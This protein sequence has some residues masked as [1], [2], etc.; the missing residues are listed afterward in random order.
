MIQDLT[1]GGPT[2]DQSVAAAA[3]SNYTNARQ[4]SQFRWILPI[5]ANHMGPQGDGYSAQTPLKMLVLITDGVEGDRGYSMPNAPIDKPLDWNWKPQISPQTCAAIKDSG[6]ALAVID[7]KYYD[8]TTDF[9]FNYW[10]GR[11]I[12]AWNSTIYGEISP[13]LQQCASGGWYFS[14]TDSADID[15]ALTQLLNK[16]N[17]TSL[18]LIK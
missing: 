10:L 2:S 13:A 17:T 14:A 7:V 6:I 18:R 5:I 3:L 11:V 9:W 12:S 15:A 16:I 1:G 4:N 8:A